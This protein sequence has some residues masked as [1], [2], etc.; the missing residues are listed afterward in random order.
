MDTSK[1]LPLGTVI[2]LKGATKKLMITG[3]CSYDPTN[4]EK[5]YDYTGCFF[6]IGIINSQQMALF[7]HNEI[8]KIYYFGLN[9]EESKAYRK[10]LK[11][12]M[13]EQKK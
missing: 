3:Y 11:D 6:P 1:Y 8:A 2:L 9:D 10:I 4:K 7:N 13:E 12:K 5:V